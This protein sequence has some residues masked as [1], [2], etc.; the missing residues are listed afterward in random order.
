M[1]RLIPDGMESVSDVLLRDCRS[2]QTCVV[3][4]PAMPVP[5]FRKSNGCM[6]CN[7]FNGDTLSGLV[8]MLFG[9]DV[10]VAVPL[11]CGSF[12]KFSGCFWCGDIDGSLD[13]LN[14]DGV[15]LGGEGR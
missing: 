10:L 6:F 4:K 3:G 9:G 8:F 15:K 12:R 11:V 13:G 2:G 5:S 14:T 7:L 1:L